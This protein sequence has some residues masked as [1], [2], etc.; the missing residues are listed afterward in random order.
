MISFESIPK[1]TEKF[2]INLF[3]RKTQFEDWW[4]I[5]VPTVA[6]P[7]SKL[8][9]IQKEYLN[10]VF[11]SIGMVAE[12][13]ALSLRK[14][15]I[16]RQPLAHNS[17]SIEVLEIPNSLKEDLSLSVRAMPDMWLG[18]WQLPIIISKIVSLRK[19]IKEFPPIEMKS[20]HTGAELM[21][22]LETFHGLGR[23]N[24]LVEE[25]T[26]RFCREHSLSVITAMFRNKGFKKNNIYGLY[27]EPFFGPEGHSEDGK[28]VSYEPLLI[29][30]DGFKPIIYDLF[31][32]IRQ[33]KSTEKINAE[34]V[35]LGL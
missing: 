24:A 34:L 22:F 28:W 27:V 2:V 16:D 3:G 5:N 11:Q 4:E 1:L 12:V 14:S 15:G 6:V 23:F 35:A 26:R 10:D 13:C 32:S 17:S 18:L 20:S 31:Y 7:R 30:P 33:H 19:T 25:M 8:R 9:T 21:I 29:S